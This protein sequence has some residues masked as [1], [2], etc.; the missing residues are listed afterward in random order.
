MQWALGYPV[1]AG[2]YALTFLIIA[3]GGAYLY[4]GMASTFNARRYAWVFTGPSWG[5]GLFAIVIGMSVALVNQPE[6]LAGSSRFLTCG[7][8]AIGAILLVCAPV[9]M[10]AMSMSYGAAASVWA[11]VVGG[12]VLVATGSSLVGSGMTD[13]KPKVLHWQGS[14]SVRDKITTPWKPMN[15]ERRVL[16]EGTMIAAGPAS[17]AIIMVAGHQILMLPGSALRIPSIGEE[18]LVRLDQ[19]SMFSRTTVAANRNMAFETSR[20]GFKVSNG[21]L[22]I[23]AGS[24]ATS[25]VVAEGGVHAGHSVFEAETVLKKGQFMLVGSGFDTM[26][27]PVSSEYRDQL[28]R[29]TRYFENPFSAANRALISGE[30]VPEKE[31]KKEEKKE[32][33]KP[34]EPAPEKSGEPM[35]AEKKD[36]AVVTPPVEAPAAPAKK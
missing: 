12:A 11:T 22:L 6:S 14:V 19:G 8:G 15:D 33:M 21:H 25:A 10:L 30:K 34:A 31:E 18:P 9:T 36:A 32:E 29:L 20:A 5:V 26:P 1:N 28:A 2:H 16:D 23:A 4:Q 24:R 7:L 27:K 35:P 3:V 17:A 13:G